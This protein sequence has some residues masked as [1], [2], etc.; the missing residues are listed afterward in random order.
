MTY[1][2]IVS[3]YISKVRYEDLLS[4]VVERAK[5]LLMDSVGV[6]LGGAVTQPGQLLIQYTKERGGV[7]EACVLGASYKTHCAQA[8]FVNGQVGCILDFDETFLNLAHPGLPLVVTALAM[9][10]HLEAS[11]KELITSLVAG[12][13]VSTRIILAIRPSPQRM[14]QVLPITS[15][16]ALGC[17]AVASKLLN[18]NPGGIN[19]ALGIA[20]VNAPLPSIWKIIQPPSTLIK[21]ANGWTAELGINSALLAEKGFPGCRDILDGDH[22]FWVL[23]GS[24]RCDYKLLTDGLGND[25]NILKTSFK[26]HSIIRRAQL[27]ID[28]ALD[29]VH[30]NGIDVPSIEELYIKVPSY[31]TGLPYNM[32]PDSMQTACWSIP[33][34][35]AMAL[36][37]YHPGPEWYA[38][39]R[40]SDPEVKSLLGQ[41]KMITDPEADRRPYQQV[42]VTVEI[43]AG[44]KSYSRAGEIAKG[45]PEKPL[46]KEELRSKFERLAGY[47]LTKGSI[48]KLIEGFE[49][50]E[51]EQRINGLMEKMLVSEARQTC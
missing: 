48:G 49:R 35:V 20:G 14:K 42:R 8:A 22:G 29:L 38:E 51:Y 32:K 4:K 17:A 1:T 2:S 27:A 18:L 24:D 21:T 26:P 28:G 9:G 12:F 47:L 13:E 31:M 11:G 43:R 16:N 39:K 45:D 41:M 5:F 46:T 44:G 40:F 30:E 25:Y 37:G 6:V 34:G 15:P 7:E 19:T 23:A 3:E 10:E 36:L 33:W 50:L